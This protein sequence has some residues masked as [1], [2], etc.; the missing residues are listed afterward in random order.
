[1][2][3]FGNHRILKN[4]FEICLVLTSIA[5]SEKIVT[6]VLHK[7]TR[8]IKMP[9]T[10]PIVQPISLVLR[11]GTDSD[12]T[13]HANDDGIFCESYDQSSC[14]DRSHS[15]EEDIDEEQ[16]NHSRET[17]NIGLLTF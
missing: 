6:S 3:V 7:P 1:M 8:R 2:V 17:K 13:K 14:I 4:I 5:C 9:S 10:C 15:F 16:A 11:G 12:S